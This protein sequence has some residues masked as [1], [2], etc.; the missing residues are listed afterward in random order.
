[1][2]INILR[3]SLFGIARDQED[4]HTFV[5]FVNSVIG[6]FVKLGVSF[7]LSHSLDYVCKAVF[8][9]L[10]HWSDLVCSFHF[11]VT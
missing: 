4:E 11:F 5:K 7:L 6:L 1:M 3:Y 9:L 10:R 2:N 8:C